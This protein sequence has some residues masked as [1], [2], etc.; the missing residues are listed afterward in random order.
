MFRFLIGNAGGF[1]QLRDLE[2]II[3]MK[4]LLGRQ[5]VRFVLTGWLNLIFVYSLYALFVW[6]GFSP[7]V[8]LLGSS[9]IG[10]PV[11]K[12]QKITIIVY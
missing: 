10:E 5:E 6:R 11:A 2:N 9:I 4:M 3:I 1:L 12:F 8:S 7:S